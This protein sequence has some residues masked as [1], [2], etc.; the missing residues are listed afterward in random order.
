[1]VDDEGGEA[2]KALDD[3]IGD[4]G[5]SRK[6]GHAISKAAVEREIERARRMMRDGDWAEARATT[7]VALWSLLFE[8]TYG[9]P[10]PL[11][12]RERLFAARLAGAMLKREFDSDP[13][14]MASFMR[15]AWK[16][17]KER[18]EWRRV[19]KRD[20]GSVGWRLMFGPNLLT[21]YKLAAARRSGQ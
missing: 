5:K 18:E 2:A 14:A 4:R 3:F 8:R 9:V 20:G 12:P 15:W 13:A 6:P 11:L 16:R 1:M 7:F 10:A 17:E 21:D 19:H